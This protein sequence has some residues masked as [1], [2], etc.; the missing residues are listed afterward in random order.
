MF[1][2]FCPLGVLEP[3]TRTVKPVDCPAGHYC[4]LGTQNPT[5]HPCPGGTFRETP[6]ARSIKDCRL[7]PA[8][9]FCTDSGYQC[10]ILDLALSLS[11]PLASDALGLP[12]GGIPGY[13]SSIAGTF[14]DM[15]KLSEGRKDRRSYT[16]KHIEKKEAI[17]RPG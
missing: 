7:C 5:Q 6:G 14:Q 2:R 17:S 12:L 15:G 13:M 3:G 9:Q 11:N 4:P 1:H 10:W 16:R 8:G